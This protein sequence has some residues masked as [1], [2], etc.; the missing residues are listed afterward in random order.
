MTLDTFQMNCMDGNMLYKVLDIPERL[1]LDLL[2]YT[3]YNKYR[4]LF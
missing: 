3:C 2:L 1:P 4:D